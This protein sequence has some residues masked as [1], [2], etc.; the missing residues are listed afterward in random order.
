MIRLSIPCITAASAAFAVLLTAPGCATKKQVRL[1]VEPVEQRVSQLEGG[2]KTTNSNVEELDTKLSATDER[3]R[4]AD[5][6]A[7]EAA[8][9]AAKANQLA[10][11]SGQKADTA[12][13]SAA[14][15]MSRANTGISSLNDRLSSIDDFALTAQEDVMFKFN[16]AQLTP[17]AKEKLASAISNIQ[18][19]NRYVIEVQGFTDPTGSAAYNKALSQRRADA[20]VQ[21]LTVEHDIPLHRVFVHGAGEVTLEQGQN[22]L[23]ARQESRRVEVRIFTPSTQETA[24]VR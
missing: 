4:A 19:H 17:E 3:A 12:N 5:A 11:E 15:A 18:S 2:A 1:A 6:R 23:Q 8:G 9:T 10:M 7:N 13:Q 20:V 14:A 16:S 24:D 22:T 21:F